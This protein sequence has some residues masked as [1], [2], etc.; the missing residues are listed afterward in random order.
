[1]T[2]D[3]GDYDAF[4]GEMIAKTVAVADRVLRDRSAAEDAAVEAMAKAHLNW[5]KVRENPHRGAWIMRVAVNVALDMRRSETRRR[6]RERRSSEGSR[7]LGLGEPSLDGVVLAEALRG[8]P[9]R[10]REA[11]ALRYLADLTEG[12]TAAVMGVSVGSVKVHV[13]R[14]LAALTTPLAEQITGG[15]RDVDA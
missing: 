11:V 14:G 1:M 3:E 6:G 7:P 13:Q 9:S 12:D 2:I 15:A 4:F 5:R 8:L 10:Q